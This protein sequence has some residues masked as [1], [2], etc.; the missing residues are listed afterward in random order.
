MTATE[1]QIRRAYE[2]I[3]AW[4]ERPWVGLAEIREVLPKIDRAEMDKTLRA[5]VAS[6]SIHLIPVANLKGLTR[7]DHDA[8]LRLGGE[9]NHAMMI[10]A[11]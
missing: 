1:A 4:E 5:M 7:A 3:S 9:D 6:R 2:T 8:A 10:E 11:R